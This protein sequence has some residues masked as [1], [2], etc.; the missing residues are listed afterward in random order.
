MPTA[1]P[2]ALRDATDNAL[3]T[4][5]KTS[6]VDAVDAG[7]ELVRRRVAGLVTVPLWREPGIVR[8][9]FADLYVGEVV[10]VDVDRHRD[11]SH[12]ETHRARLVSAAHGGTSG[13]VVLRFPLDR[14]LRD[15]LVELALV[16]AIRVAPIGPQ[17]S[18]TYPR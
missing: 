6:A 10:D 12:V 18:A 5:V 11:G 8:L 14:N 1:T 17:T 16:S 15:H 3:R 2:V 9:R 4:K 13:A 7:A